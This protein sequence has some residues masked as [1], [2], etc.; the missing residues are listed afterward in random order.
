MQS[1]S[2][3]SFYFSL[4]RPENY[5]PDHWKQQLSL[6][7]IRKVEKEC[8]NYM[9][10]LNYVKFNDTGTSTTSETTSESNNIETS[11]SATR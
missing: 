7:N 11:T 6:E 10:L 3:S 8:K 5:D 1:K 2:R 4:Y 9:K